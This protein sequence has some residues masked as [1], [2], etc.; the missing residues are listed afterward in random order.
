MAF[1]LL[2]VPAFVSAKDAEPPA[3]AALLPAL[4][5][6]SD[7]ARAGELE[8]LCQALR[9][10]LLEA[11]ALAPLQLSQPIGCEEIHSFGDFRPREDSVYAPGETILLYTE[12]HNFGLEETETDSYRLAVRQD[13]ALYDAQGRMAWEREAVVDFERLLHSPIHDLY[14]DNALVI[15]EGMP[16]GTYKLVLQLHDLIKEQ[17][18]T[19]FFEF[20]VEIPKT[21][22]ENNQ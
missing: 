18:T 13:I 22:P 10:L 7:L 2:L 15:P 11:Q 5:Q 17:S 14:L 8:E 21:S 6:A 16:S 12:V 20:R 9:Q 1:L 4:E 19:A 3:G